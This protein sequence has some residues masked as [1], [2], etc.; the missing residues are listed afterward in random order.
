MYGGRDMPLRSDRS[1]PSNGGFTPQGPTPKELR[2]T[3]GWPLAF[4]I[5][6]EA[7][8]EGNARLLG[9]NTRLLAENEELVRRNAALELE[10]AITAE[11]LEEN[12][13]LRGDLEK[14]EERLINAK[15]EWAE[16]LRNA[17]AVPRGMVLVPVH[18]LAELQRDQGTLRDLRSQMSRAA[19]M[20]TD[21]LLS[22]LAQ[23][24]PG[25][26]PTP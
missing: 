18:R 10:S 16:R 25:T 3:Y 11:L 17:E 6:M 7:M 1:N 5:A 2:K 14:A 19:R 26:T 9:E 23:L 13:S 8:L 24:D 20:S 12:E 15:R 4:E 22:L 21:D